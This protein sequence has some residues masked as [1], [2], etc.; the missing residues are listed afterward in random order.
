MNEFAAEISE[1]RILDADADHIYVT[2]SASDEATQAQQR[3][4]ANPLWGQLTGEVFVVDDAVRGL[5]VGLQGAQAMLNDLA[6]T[7]GVAPG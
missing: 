1:E 5:A 7:F 2:V 4:T 3:F 6:R